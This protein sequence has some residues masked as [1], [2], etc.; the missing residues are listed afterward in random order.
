MKTYSLSVI[1]HYDMVLFLKDN[2]IKDSSKLLIQ[3]FCAKADLNLIKDFQAFF[4]KNFP[5]A[6]LIGSTSDG[7]IESSTINAKNRS[8]VVF[9][10][11]D[12]TTLSSILLEHSLTSHNNFD[13]GKRMASAIIKKDTKLLIT[14]TDGL[15]T[16]GEEYVKGIE[17]LSK[18]CVV[19][20]GMAGDNGL[21]KETFVF[22]K[23]S[24]TKDGA[25]GV[26]LNSKELQVISDYSFD[27]S[28]IGKKLTV[29]KAYKNRVYEI[30]GVSSVDI[31]AK[32]LGEDLAKCLPQTGIEFPLILD[33]DGVSVGRA[34]LQKHD[35]GSL[36]FAGNIAEG[37]TVRFGIGNIDAL[38]KKGNSHVKRM[39]QNAKFQPETFF[40]YSC[41]ARR[42]F[43]G[44]HIS[45]EIKPYANLAPT[46]GFF[47]YGEFY[48][49]DAKNQLLNETMTVIGLCENNKPN[50]IVPEDFKY[51]SQKLEINPLHVISHLA[52]RVSNELEELNNTLEEKIQ[53][54]TDYIYEQAYLEKL[55]GLPNRLKLLKELPNNLGKILFLI[56]IDDFSQINDFYGHDIGDIILKN[57]SIVLNDCAIKEQAFVFKLPSDEY[58]L[59][60]K[61]KYTE[62]ELKPLINRIIHKI[63]STNILT[64]D[65]TIN[66][67]V[68]IGVAMVA[69]D[70]SALINADMALKLAKRSNK[71]YLI[72]DESLMLSQHYE[73]NIK[74]TKLL[75][76]AI[77]SDN[78]IP[79]FQPIYCSKTKE[80]KKYEALVRLRDDDGAI[81]SPAVFL[82][83]AQKTKLYSYITKIMIEKT[84]SF[85]KK[86]GLNFNLNLSFE[87]ILNHGTR[88]FIFKKIKEYDIAAQ[89]TF[90]IL[91]TQQMEDEDFVME[92]IEE[93]Y[94]CGADI[95]IDDFGSG[96]ANFI[97]MTKM[98]SDYIKIDGS[99]IKNIDTNQNSLLIVETIIVFAKKLNMKTVAEFVHSKEVY[100]IVCGL[101]VDFIQ[102]YHMC[103]PL[104]D[105]NNEQFFSD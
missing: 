8:V 76:N 54:R 99:L 65:F 64:R 15:Y 42:R 92:F 103:Q 82:D 97:H 63:A 21:L 95:A 94:S 33:I 67:D 72:F 74:I 38:I 22:D 78:I 13:L 36:T 4:N 25:V 5:K 41:M 80:I 73:R 23:N 39:L 19:A 11:F 85:F 29:T 10:K 62:A 31:Y 50:K 57:I 87:D 61:N 98:K 28:A 26:T 6:T 47:T 71:K 3:I 77:S 66:L 88:D 44:E 14:F 56:N 17:Q 45:K 86:N 51:N 55:T 46:A 52:N 43:I 93:I 53:E 91:E 2:S 48:H 58:A 27:W 1:N 40:I 101:G 89:L 60:L 18:N 35:D 83:I 81:I 104:A 102:G 75:R 7:T 96:F 100:D 30:D 37:T 20:G 70:K 59:I 105:I 84:F 34:V 68:T 69:S 90:E 24:I 16:N 79:Y 9:T 49:S 32:Y 12:N